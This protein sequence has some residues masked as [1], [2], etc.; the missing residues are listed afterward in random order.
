MINSLVPGRS[1]MKPKDTAWWLRRER[2]VIDGARGEVIES[3]KDRI[4]ISKGLIVAKKNR[5]CILI[6]HY[7]VF[8][9]KS[10]FGV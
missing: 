6:Q 5:Q 7:I 8:F 10:I 4:Q 9:S 3:K 1:G 2:K